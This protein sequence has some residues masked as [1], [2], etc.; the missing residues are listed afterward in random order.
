[1][2]HPEEVCRVVLLLE[3]HQPVV[4]RTVG[5]GDA[6]DFVLGEE[7]DVRAA[8][9]ERLRAVEEFACPGDAALVLGG[10]LPAGVHVQGVVGVSARVG[11]CIRR[12]AGRLAAERANEDLAMRRWQLAGVFDDG[13]DRT[14]AELREVVRLPVIARTRRQERI[15][16]L[17]PCGVRLHADVFAVCRAESAQRLNQLLAISGVARI[18]QGERDDLFSV[19]LFGQERQ[20]RRL[21]GKHPD[22]EVVRHR[23]GETGELS[24]YGFPLV[25]REGDEPAQH[26]RPDGMELELKSG[27]NTEVPP[28]T[29]QSPEEVIVFPFAGVHLTAIR[30][31]DIRGEQV[32]NGHAVFP[33]QPAEAA[34]ERQAGHARG[35]VDAQGRGEAVVLCRRVNVGEGAARLD[36]RTAGVGVDLDALHQRE[37]DHEAI[38]ADGIARNVVPAPSDRDEQVVLAPKFDGLH[39]IFRRRAAGDQCGPAV[40]HG[41]PDLSYFVVV[42]VAR[43]KHISLQERFKIVDLFFL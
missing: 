33:A 21:P 9:G 40:Y 27:D 16:G 24:E 1:M 23:L 15:K 30:R 36:G 4:C 25:V 18:A 14:V 34:A 31:D 6:V 29:T 13:V 43:K 10:R 32:V 39:D 5:E 12:Y 3:L 19:H 22:V 7:V 38:V 2:V 28:A 41:V 11:R 26:V 42:R 8:A 20:W 37:V 35:R 17:L